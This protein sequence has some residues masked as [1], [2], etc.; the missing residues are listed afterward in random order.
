NWTWDGSEA[1]IGYCVAKDLE[2][3]FYI[4]G[5]TV[6]PGNQ[7]DW[8][9]VKLDNKGEYQWHQTWGSRGV[10]ICLDIAIDSLG[11]IYM[12][13]VVQNTVLMADDACL[14]KFNSSGHFLWYYSWINSYCP[15]IIIDPLDNV[16]LAINDYF[17]GDIGIL[18][19]SNSGDLQWISSWGT[20]NLDWARNIALDQSQNIYITGSTYKIGEEGGI[21]LFF[22]KF[23]NKGHFLSYRT[24]GGED[25][26]SGYCII[27][28]PLLDIY[29]SGIT[30]SYGSGAKDLCL[31]KYS[32]LNTLMWER[33]WGNDGDNSGNAIDFDP[34][35][36]IYVIG[37]S[38]QDAN[39]DIC[40]LKYNNEGEAK[41]YFLWGGPGNQ[42][43]YDIMLLNSTCLIAVGTTEG[44]ICLLKFELQEA[45]GIF[46]PYTPWYPLF[47]LALSLG[48]ISII[49]IVL[50]KKWS[51][52]HQNK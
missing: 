23:N 32:P 51:F 27:I 11:Y 2:G 39:E 40:L 48:L 15:A 52:R 9:L 30:S 8:V 6:V 49:I 16:I 37:S 7:Q 13:G 43:G 3:N 35:G 1:D 29:I 42:H 31:L 17:N 19:Y 10:D 34:D 50:F 41:G 5:Y 25:E 24:W 44:D 36:N 20:T 28:S 14:A 22:T 18:N 33:T 47:I 12:V 26:D 38:E 45:D 46:E 21:E 4:G